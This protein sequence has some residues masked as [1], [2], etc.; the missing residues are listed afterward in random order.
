MPAN[1]NGLTAIVRGRA[2]ARVPNSF[3]YIK[4]VLDEAYFDKFGC[5]PTGY[6]ADCLD[7]IAVQW[8]ANGVVL[9]S[10]KVELHRGSED[11]G[12]RTIDG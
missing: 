6:D 9:T 2:N 12:F 3:D 4:D 8:V 7:A 1:P 5:E 10:D 11:L